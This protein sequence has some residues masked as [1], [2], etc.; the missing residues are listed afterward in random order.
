MFQ[1]SDGCGFDEVVS[2]VQ[3]VQVRHDPRATGDPYDTS[4]IPMRVSSSASNCEV[5]KLWSY[6]IFINQ[7]VSVEFKKVI[8]ARYASA[9]IHRA[10]T[11]IKLSNTSI[12][13]NNVILEVFRILNNQ[14]LQL[15]IVVM[16][17]PPFYP[18]IPF[19]RSNTIHCNPSALHR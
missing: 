5:I 17:H 16:I 15:P 3:G 8:I 6:E 13:E 7:E 4:L 1:A 11:K 2:S 18:I 12:H 19:K 14:C 10:A 9:R